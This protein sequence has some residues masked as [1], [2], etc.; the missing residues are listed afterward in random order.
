MIWLEYSFNSSCISEVTIIILPPLAQTSWMFETILLLSWEYDSKE[1]VIINNS[2]IGLIIFIG[3][4]LICF[5]KFH[6]AN[7]LV[8]GS[9]IIWLGSLSDLI[10]SFFK[11]GVNLISS[12]LDK[13]SFP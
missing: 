7:N 2:I 1:K 10:I 9:N 11:S 13:N 5:L 4:Y 3:F 8:E 12:N 6:S